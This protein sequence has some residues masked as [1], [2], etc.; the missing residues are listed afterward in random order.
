MQRQ[1]GPLPARA[2]RGL[3]DRR[4]LLPRELCPEPIRLHDVLGR[5]VR[6]LLGPRGASGAFRPPFPS[7][8]DPGGVTICDSTALQPPRPFF[9]AGHMPAWGGPGRRGLL[10]GLLR[11]R[12]VLRGGCCLFWPSVLDDCHTRAMLG[13]SHRE[14]H[15]PPFITLVAVFSLRLPT[16]SGSSDRIG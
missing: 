14:K 2:I 8:F 11:P 4:Q 6:Y 3:D 13:P 16:Y 7:M 15:A 10:S 9:P 1:R 5:G 12:A